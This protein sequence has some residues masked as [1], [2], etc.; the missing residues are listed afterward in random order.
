MNNEHITEYVI[1]ELSKHRNP[2]DIIIAICEKSGMPWQDAQEFVSN[3]R[4]D[5]QNEISS[6]YSSMPYLVRLLFFVLLGI[7]SLFGMA[8]W[9]GLPNSL[10]SRG[11]PTAEGTIVYSELVERP[12]GEHGAYV[13]FEAFVSYQYSVNGRQYISDSVTSIDRDGVID[14]RYEQEII[15]QY[16]TGREVMIH[17]N[18]R[19]PYEAVLEPGIIL[20][21]ALFIGFMPILLGLMCSASIIG[22]ISLPKFRLKVWRD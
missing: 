10:A 21:L 2:N 12:C 14:S 9:L 19:K 7:V 22:L 16:P 13:C 1:T 18:P 6:G 3:V 5:H 20:K 11:W 8:S 17:Y 15:S 4:N